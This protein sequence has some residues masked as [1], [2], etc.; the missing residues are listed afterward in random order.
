MMTPEQ[1]KEKAVLLEKKV[2]ELEDLKEE[3]EELKK[4]MNLRIKR[5]EINTKEIINE[6]LLKKKIEFR[7]DKSNFE[8]NKAQTEERLREISEEIE[9]EKEFFKSKKKQ[10]LEALKKIFQEKAQGFPWLAKAYGDYLSLRDK[11]IADYLRKKKHPAL[12]AS[13]AVQLM[14]S[15]K[16]Q[17]T[18]ENRVLKYLLEYYENLFPWLIDFKG[19]DLDDLIRKIIE[20]DQGDEGYKENDDP[21]K[22]WLTEAEYKNLSSVKKYQLALDRYWKKKK[23]PWEVGRDYERYIGYLYEKEGFQ[24]YYEGIVKGF[25]D[26]GRDLICINGEMIE[27]VQCK[28]WSQHKTIH[29]K[30]INQLFGTTV[31]YW[32]QKFGGNNTQLELFPSLLQSKQII[33]CFITSTKLSDPARQFASALGVKIKESFPFSQYPSVKC[34]VSRKN[35]EK[36]YHLPFDQQYDKTIVEEERNECYVQTVGE[37]EA[38]GFRRAFRWRG[39]TSNVTEKV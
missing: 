7:E 5:N 29:E 9:E 25:E 6:Y 26:L 36:I 4:G 31:M 33:P 3:L 35:N 11:E 32:I 23:T 28:Y 8:V 2:E 15:E 21:A 16:R 27:I 12:I 37:A 17:L 19:E 14:R 38:L 18:K 10:D 13:D 39:K 1:F 20:G 34:N 30:H 22:I 24:V